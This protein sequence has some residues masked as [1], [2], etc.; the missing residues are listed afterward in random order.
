[1][2]HGPLPRS[3]DGPGPA[4]TAPGDLAAPSNGPSPTSP[5]GAAL[6]SDPARLAAVRRLVDLNSPESLDR[7]TTLAA[8]LLRSPLA[9]VSLLGDEQL[10]AGAS[11]LRPEQRLP[12]PTCDSLCAT[13]MLLDGP[14]AVA[15][16]VHD[17]RVRDLA[18]VAR[19][20]VASYLG[21]PL[22]DRAGH[23]VGAL[24]VYGGQVRTW[25]SADVGVLAEIATSV[26][27]EL[28]LLAVTEEMSA[29]TARLELAMDAADAGSFDWHLDTG[30][31]TWD[32]RLLHLFGYERGDF[33]E[34]IDSFA[35]RLHPDDVARV[36]STLATVVD[37][38]GDLAV[39]YRIVRPDDTQRRVVSRGRVVGRTKSLAGR[40]LGIAH[41]A[42]DLLEGRDRLA[43]VLATMPDAFLSVDAGWDL[44]WV[45][46]EA[47]RLLAGTAEQLVGTSL[48]ELDQRLF[49]PR[50]R[51]EQAAASG[52]PTSFEHHVE[53]TGTSFQVRVWPQQDGLGIYLLDT[54]E[55]T[56]AELDREQA[57]V[58]RERAYAAAETAN[59]RLALLAD[60]TTRLSASLEPRAV[61]STLTEVVVRSLGAW[62]VV[63]V[64]REV[65]GDLDVTAGEGELAVVVSRHAERRRDGELRSA[66]AG[67]PLSRQDESGP[68]AVLRTGRRDRATSLL[69]DAALEGLDAAARDR[70]DAVGTGPAVTVPLVSRGRRLGAVTVVSPSVGAGPWIDQGLLDDLAG[71][72][73]VALDNALLFRRER[74]AGLTLQRSLLPRE[75]PQLPGLTTAV[76]YLPGATG[77]QVGGDWFQGL[78]VDGALV[79]AIG[80]VMGHGMRSAA[81]MGQLRAIVATLALEG[82]G[83]GP[84]LTRLSQ[85]VDELLDLELATLLVARYDPRTRE[86]SFASAGHPPPLH[87]PVTGMPRFLDIDPGPPLGT[88]AGDYGEVAVE[89]GYGDTVVLYTDG[90]VESRGASLTDGLEQL[91]QALIELRLPPEAVAEHVLRALGRRWGGEDDVA[92]LVF[93]HVEPSELADAEPTEPEPAPGGRGPR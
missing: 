89:L 67:L 61:L 56:R 45:N 13:T 20:D 15:D 17:V 92:L 93:S 9:Q 36:E 90:L 5:E 85:R 83:P 32:D 1:M 26:V 63:V 64:P 37:Q 48:W 86:L 23:P 71:R 41:D 54:T 21:V 39:E 69:S 91:R 88:F 74:E 42:T 84:L 25:S 53:Q 72:A 46:A 4:G 82:H 44:L 43:Q 50:D 70:L 6:L 73:A 33:V 52:E 75:V 38:G 47:E 55:R 81:H 77:A 87:A 80:D 35:A 62:T 79:L 78:L 76:R 51:Y 65:A 66:L 19:G 22:R 18:P 8:L 12:S 24:C 60:A 34:H 3:Q 10:I 31:L 58:E 29:E 57:V 2:S 30:L 28:E 49:G 40:L 68:G 27:A 7:L 14:L 16:A 11:G 59:T